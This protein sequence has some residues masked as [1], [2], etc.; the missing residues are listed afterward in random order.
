M[1][2]VEDLRHLELAEPPGPAP[3]ALKSIR[4]RFVSPFMTPVPVIVMATGP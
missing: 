2:I 1:V 3:V 4:A